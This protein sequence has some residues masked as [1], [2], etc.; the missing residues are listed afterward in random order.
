MREITIA[1]AGNPNSGKTTLFNLLT[2]ARQH[3]GNYPGITVEK[4]EGYLKQGEVVLRLVDLPGTYSL[5]AYSQEEL[6]AR[7]FLVE[8]RP[9]L[10]VDVI[11][12]TNLERHMYLA[13]Q[14]MELGV[15]LLLVLNMMDEVKKKGIDINIDD[16]KG[17]INNKCI[18]T[19]IFKNPQFEKGIHSDLFLPLSFGFLNNG[20]K[21]S[22]YRRLSC[23]HVLR[24][25]TAY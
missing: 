17:N 8:E 24:P 10:V 15:P 23:W 4:R 9:S 7:N 13:V 16:I 1:L 2:G 21:G 25:E 12:A 19:K 6:V 18:I 11:D 3:V 14:F 20:S 22:G 5:T